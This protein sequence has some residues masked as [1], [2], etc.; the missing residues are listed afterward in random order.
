MDNPLLEKAKS[1]CA[2]KEVCAFEIQQKLKNWGENDFEAYVDVL[3]EQGFINHE[4][5][6]KA[7]VN[8]KYRLNK[9]GKQKI[10]AALKAKKIEYLHIENALKLIPEEEYYQ[11]LQDFLQKKRASFGKNLNAREKN[12]LFNFAASKGFEFDLIYRAID[13]L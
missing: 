11:T 4:R 10:R 12:K 6:A 1:I 8:D 5:Y 2:K 13:Q 7:F 3:Q 9:W